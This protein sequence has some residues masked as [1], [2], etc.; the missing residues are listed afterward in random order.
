MIGP[1]ACIDGT[2]RPRTGVLFGHVDVVAGSP[3]SGPMHPTVDLELRLFEAPRSGLTHFA[4]RTLRLGSSLYVGEV[5]LRHDTEAAP[6]GLAVAT[7]VNGLRL[8]VATSDE[9]PE[10]TPTPRLT[11][12][13]RV[14]AGVVQL[15]AQLDTPQGSVT[16]AVLALL[17]EEAAI[18]V[19]GGTG[20]ALD[21][22][23][24]R[25]LDK[26]RVGPVR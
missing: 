24:L 23:Q 3:P 16:G 18:D 8:P 2:D 7:F 15:A 22:L 1:E 19:V 17:A 4:G 5:E 20:V 6:F 14:S 26:V 9:P 25:F 11:G 21:E 12:A 10:V 13:D